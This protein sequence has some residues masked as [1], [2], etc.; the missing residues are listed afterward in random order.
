LLAPP[1]RLAVPARLGLG[2]LRW[3]GAAQ[4]VVLRRRR[5]RVLA[6]TRNQPLQPGQPRK[7]LAVLRPK[8]LHLTGLLLQPVYLAGLRLQ[9]L[10][11]APR[12]RDQIGTRQRREV[13]QGT[14]H[15]HSPTQEPSRRTH[16]PT[17]RVLDD[18]DRS[19]PQGRSPR[20]AISSHSMEW[21]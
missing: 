18:S 5:P 4:V 1:A 16:L 9:P 19:Q 13:D 21:P 12:Q 10:R 3:R 14:G 20:S 17:R 8:L 2:L 15:R 7:Q 6:V 11:L